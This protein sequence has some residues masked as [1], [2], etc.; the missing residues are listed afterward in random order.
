M[1][2]NRGEKSQETLWTKK[3][4]LTKTPHLAFSFPL[5]FML[6]FI[7]EHCLIDRKRGNRRRHL[8]FTAR[9]GNSTRIPRRKSRI[10]H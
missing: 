9:R 6:P 1:R 4:G 7:C 2:V 8:C 10:V 3:T 5:N